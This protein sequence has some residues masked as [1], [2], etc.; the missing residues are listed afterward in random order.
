[1]S[2]SPE[3]SECEISACNFA[4]LC[5]IP[6]GFYGDTYNCHERAWF[7][8]FREKCAFFLAL[9]EEE[10]R[11]AKTVFPNAE[12][13]AVGNPLWEE[14]SFPETTR[15]NV[16]KDLQVEWDEILVLAPGSKSAG[17]N[18]ANWTALLSALYLI[19]GS[20]F[21]VRI[22][23]HPGDVTPHE[24]YKEFMQWSPVNVEMTPAS[25]KT[26]L[27]V[28]GADLV[29]E[30]NSSIAIEA[31]HQGIPVISLANPFAERRLIST[32]GSPIWEPCRLRVSV[33]G[34]DEPPYLAK[35]IHALLYEKTGT[36]LAKRQAIVYPKVLQRGDAVRK[37]FE[38]LQ[39]FMRVSA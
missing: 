18:I 30:W 6:F 12:C 34:S 33:L 11:K 17:I 4:I 31:A 9:N 3:L 13:V 21:K 32:S 7:A 8:P 28:P 27:F 36:A 1:M 14:F 20:K 35:Q 38:Y 24:I 39:K 10:A 37:M 23:L 5:D 15:E 25:M 2:S 29:A 22:A 16:R 26:S 19:K